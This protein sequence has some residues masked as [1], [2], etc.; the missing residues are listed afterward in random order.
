LKNSKGSSVQGEDRMTYD[1]AKG[2]SDGV[3]LVKKKM[4]GGES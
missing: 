2:V 3:V 4:T 1:T